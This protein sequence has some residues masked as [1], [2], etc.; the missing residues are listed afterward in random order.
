MLLIFCVHSAIYY[1]I[2]KKKKM[3]KENESSN[4]KDKKITRKQALSKANNMAA[5]SMMS[6]INMSQDTSV[7]NSED[8]QTLGE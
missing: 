2:N 5:K 8:D 4:P 7:A 1:Y 3:E 6:S